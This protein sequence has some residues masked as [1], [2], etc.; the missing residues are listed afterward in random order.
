L[1]FRSPWPSLHELLA[2]EFLFR[3]SGQAFLLV[4]ALLA[5]MISA[6]LRRTTF[7]TRNPA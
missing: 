7:E 1:L 6:V 2:S 4:V 3:P 5:V